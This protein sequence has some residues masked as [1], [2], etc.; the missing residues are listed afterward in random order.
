MYRTPAEETFHIS[1]NKGTLTKCLDDL[2]GGIK[3]NTEVIL[4]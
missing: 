2:T 3:H 1:R 4:Y